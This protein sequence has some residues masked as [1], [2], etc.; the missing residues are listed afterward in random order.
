MWPAALRLDLL[1]VLL[2]A[3]LSSCLRG[4]CGRILGLGVKASTFRDSALPLIYIGVV[5]IALNS[6][7]MS[8]TGTC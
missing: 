3:V 1:T 5:F 6:S 8:F 7:C 2:N 4:R